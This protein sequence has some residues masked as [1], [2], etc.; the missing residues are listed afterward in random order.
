MKKLF[1]LLFLIGLHYPAYAEINV[2]YGPQAG[3]K[4]LKN[5]NITTVGFTGSWIFG[6]RTALGIE[7]K[8][9]LPNLHFTYYS[10]AGLFGEY[11]F[12]STN[13]LFPSIKLGIN[14]LSTDMFLPDVLSIGLTSEIFINYRLTNKSWIKTGIGTVFHENKELSGIIIGLTLNY[15]P[16]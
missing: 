12:F 6:N 15:Q 8:N 4:F 1:L 2:R 7:I 3:Q 14:A 11:I 13:E 16:H 5:R 10:S 9:S